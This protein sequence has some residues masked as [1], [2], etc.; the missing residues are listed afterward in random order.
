MVRMLLRGHRTVAAAAAEADAP[1][2]SGP[3]Y[4]NRRP[5]R[6]FSILQSLQHENI[7]QVH[8]LRFDGMSALIIEDF[9]SGSNLSERLL[10]S[11]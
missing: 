5:V 2:P 3:P 1:A 9:A 6:E 7:V 4:R 11:G 10:K 8:D